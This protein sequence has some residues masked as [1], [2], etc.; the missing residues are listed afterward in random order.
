MRIRHWLTSLC[1][2]VTP[3]AHAAVGAIDN[4]PASTL[5]IPYFEVDLASATGKNTVVS[6][7]NTTATAVMGN[8]TLW[9]DAGIPAFN[10]SIYFTGYDTAAIDLR[11]VLA[12][13]LPRTASAGQD[14]TDTISHKGF[15]SQDINFASC[16]GIL[17]P[18]TVP[19]ATVADVAAMLT[20]SPSTSRYAGQCVGS[21]K[22]DGVARGYITID[23]ANR[24]AG[25][26]MDPGNVDYFNPQSA[27]I[28]ATNQ[29][30]LVGD[31]L[32]T[33]QATGQLSAF[34]AVSVESDPADQRLTTAGN[35]T[36]YGRMH[37]WDA[38]D[39]REPLAT[40][41][42]V[43]GD[44]GTSAAIIWRDPKT[45][46]AAFSCATGRPAYAPLGQN[47][48]RMI[49]SASSQVPLTPAALAPIATQVAPLTNAYLGYGSTEKIGWLY[50]NLNTAVAPGNNPP[51]QVGAAQAFVTVL[52]P[53]DG[54]TR[55]TA[56]STC[57][58]LDS[59]IAASNFIIP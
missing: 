42:S 31:Y 27:N 13:V 18:A 49:N 50:M 35:Y 43:Q 23:T 34:N 45:A 29:N 40:N 32:M 26:G 8:V 20:G 10:F 44:S 2:L 55:F 53:V 7:T 21:A 47:Q 14:P 37:G 39:N 57:T 1:L 46:P 48:A 6:V 33:N 15:L 11:Q 56:G 5:L 51:S 38:T 12:G 3:W 59:A 52:R 17:P 54:V 16:N 41:W 28:V 24:C 36:F 22:G 30:V 58:P 25:A 4:V 9:S 19:S